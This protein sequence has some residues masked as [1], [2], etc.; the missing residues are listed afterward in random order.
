MKKTITFVV[1]STIFLA[2]VVSQGFEITAFTGYSFNSNMNTYYGKYNVDDSPNYG[3]LLGVSPQQ[4]IFVEF[5]YNRTDTRMDYYYLGTAEPIDMLSEY[6]HIG[7][8]RQMGT[9]NIKPFGA[10]SLGATRFHLKQTTGDLQQSTQWA[11][12]LAL[13]GGAK[14]LIGERLGVRLQAR[15][16]MPMQFSG[17][18]LGAGT[19]GASAGAGFRI[20]IVQFDLSAGLIL[21][22]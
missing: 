15:L 6:Y 18:W 2:H 10:V 14:I 19:G 16:G 9:G 4:D 5:M 11:M 20:P 3:F 7:G 17:L 21:R 12:S 8:L 1:I 13:G 22:I